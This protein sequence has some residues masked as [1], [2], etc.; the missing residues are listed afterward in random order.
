MSLRYKVVV[1]KQLKV[2]SDDNDNDDGD[3]DD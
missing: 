3:D 1:L 2:I